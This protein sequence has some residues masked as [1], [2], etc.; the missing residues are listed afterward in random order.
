MDLKELKEQLGNNPSIKSKLIVLFHYLMKEKTN[1]S[2][3]YVANEDVSRLFEE[4]CPDICKDSDK[5]RNYRKNHIINLLRMLKRL[6][7]N[8]WNRSMEKGTDS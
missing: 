5:K 4:L 8:S 1:G 6:C 2:Y 3:E 7:V